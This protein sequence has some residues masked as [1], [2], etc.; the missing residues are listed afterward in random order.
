MGTGASPRSA[1]QKYRDSKAATLRDDFGE[2]ARYR[3]A[4]AALQPP[5]PGE[6]RVVFFGDSFTSIW[7]L[8][9]YFPGKPYI[10]RGIGGQTTPPPTDSISATSAPWST[11]RACSNVT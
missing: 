3:E 2:L 8:D 10:N 9:E 7:H 1:L 11:R 4:N 6:S 5:T